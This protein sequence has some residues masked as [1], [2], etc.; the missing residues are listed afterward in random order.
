MATSRL[1]FLAQ[2][3]FRQKKWFFLG[4]LAKFGMNL[5]HGDGNTRQCMASAAV[6]YKQSFGFRRAAVH[7]R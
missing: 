1:L 5:L 4:S 2:G 6:A 7:I 3:K